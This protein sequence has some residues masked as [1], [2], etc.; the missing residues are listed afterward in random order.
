MSPK[1]LVSLRIKNVCL[2]LIGYYAGFMG[3]RTFRNIP[4][5]GDV[6]INSHGDS[7]SSSDKENAYCH[8]RGNRYYLHS[9]LLEVLQVCC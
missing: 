4:R 9:F 2:I 8:G 7:E 5:L 1:Y 6:D 3:E